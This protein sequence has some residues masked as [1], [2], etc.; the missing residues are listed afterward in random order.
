MEQFLASSHLNGTVFQIFVGSYLG[1]FHD[2]FEDGL[3]EL[4]EEQ[5]GDFGVAHCIS[6]F[7]T[8][9]F[10]FQDVFVD[11]WGFHSERF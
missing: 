7:V 3:W 8:Q 10:K 2:V 6:C 9:F 1:S 4:F 11:L 5:V